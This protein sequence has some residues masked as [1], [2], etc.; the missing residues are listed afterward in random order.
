[1][2][3]MNCVKCCV[4]CSGWCDPAVLCST[5][6]LSAMKCVV[7]QLLH[8]FLY[9]SNFMRPHQKDSNIQGFTPCAISLLAEKCSA[10]FASRFQESS[11]QTES[12]E[13]RC[14]FLLRQR[15]LAQTRKL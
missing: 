11:F 7:V 15:N 6:Y 14:C 4:G 5:V 10:A 12:K 8:W 2:D 1:M 9:F 3:V 13:K